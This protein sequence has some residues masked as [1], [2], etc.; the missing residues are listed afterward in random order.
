M[1]GFIYNNPK[2]AHEDDGFWTFNEGKPEPHAYWCVLKELKNDVL[3]MAPVWFDLM[4]NLS[5]SIIETCPVQMSDGAIHMTI[6]VGRCVRRGKEEL[7]TEPVMF[8]NPEWAKKAC[9]IVARMCR[10]D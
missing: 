5:N 9:K 3:F 6:G 4:D 8:M 1:R 10:G 2:L 7:T